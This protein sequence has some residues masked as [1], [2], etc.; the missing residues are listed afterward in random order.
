MRIIA[1]VAFKNPNVS[2]MGINNNAKAEPKV[3]GAFG[4]SPEPNP[5]PQNTI[6]R[7]NQDMFLKLIAGLYKVLVSMKLQWIVCTIQLKS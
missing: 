7:L 3:P 1:N 4:S 2:Q 6:Q 5:T